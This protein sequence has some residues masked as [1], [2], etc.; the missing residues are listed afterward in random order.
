MTIKELG[1]VRAD[2][3]RTRKVKWDDRSGDIYVEGKPS[4][5]GGGT[6]KK[7]GMTTNNSGDAI[8]FAKSWLE[9]DKSR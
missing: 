7:I 1:K 3:G 9:H 2:G 5:F 8:N 6:M 4:L